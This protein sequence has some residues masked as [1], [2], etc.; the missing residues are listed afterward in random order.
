MSNFIKGE[1]LLLYV[2]DSGGSIYRP[3]ACLT[4]NSLSQTRNVIEAQTKCDPGVTIKQS[5][6]ML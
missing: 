1:I 3:V 2:Y 4:S 5:G 6:V